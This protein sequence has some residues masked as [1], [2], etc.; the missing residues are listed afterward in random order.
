M[1]LPAKETSTFIVRLWTETRQGKQ[2]GVIWRGVIEHVQ[3]GKRQAFEE[4]QQ[5]FEFIRRQIRFTREGGK[6]DEK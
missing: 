4:L 1:G 2:Q 6:E 5:A 3:G